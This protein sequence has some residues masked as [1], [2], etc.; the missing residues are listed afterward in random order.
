M[1]PLGTDSTAVLDAPITDTSADLSVDEGSSDEST[2]STS[3]DQPST[4][5]DTSTPSTEGPAADDDSAV[6]VNGKLAP[7]VA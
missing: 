3:V 6:V 7:G 2:G 5:G 1:A 4:T